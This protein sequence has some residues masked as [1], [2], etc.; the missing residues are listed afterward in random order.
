MSSEEYSSSDKVAIQAAYDRVHAYKDT[1]TWG[2]FLDLRSALFRIYLQEWLSDKWR[3]V[4]RSIIWVLNNSWYKGVPK[5]READSM[6]WII[7]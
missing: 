6:A 5:L 7:E 1:M 3:E 4:V 2:Q